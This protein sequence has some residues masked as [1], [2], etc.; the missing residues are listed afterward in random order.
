MIRNEL[1]QQILAAI[2]GGGGTAMPV[3]PAGGLYQASG[4]TWT[5]IN[6]TISNSFF[7]WSTDTT[8]TDPGSGFVKCNNADPTLATELYISTTTQTG[9]DVKEV[10]SRLGSKTV[11]YGADSINNANYYIS[12][13]TGPITDNSTWVTVPVVGVDGSGPIDSGAELVISI[14]PFFDPRNISIE[15]LLD[16]LSLATDQQPSGTGEANSIQIEFGAAQGTVSDPVQIDASGLVTFN[17]S[18]LYRIKISATYGRIGGAGQSELRFRAL[19]NGVQAGQTIGVELD[20]DKV[21]IPFADEAWLNI[22]AGV[23]IAYEL[24][25]DSSGNDSGGI[26][27]PVVTAVT[28]PNWNPC[29]CAA[30]RIERWS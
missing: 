24:M 28:A 4:S 6:D 22:P 16:G 18:G 15:R 13:V 5:N 23:T 26:F 20:N 30:I 19:V 11:L 27:Q 9:A 25:R 29:T 3:A 2:E 14:I 17:Q 12:D 1:L 10:L 7:E 8:A 21:I